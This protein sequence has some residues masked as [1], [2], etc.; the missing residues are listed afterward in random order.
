MQASPLMDGK[1]FARDME[2]IYRQ[3]WRAWCDQTSART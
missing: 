3:M 1:G 2:A